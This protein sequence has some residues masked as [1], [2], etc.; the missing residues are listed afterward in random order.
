[1][2]IRPSCVRYLGMAKPRL[3]ATISMMV[4]MTNLIM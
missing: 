2:F 1:M 3:T 4:A